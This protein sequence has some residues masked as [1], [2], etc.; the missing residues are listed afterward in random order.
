MARNSCSESL[1]SSGPLLLRIPYCPRIEQFMS[2]SLAAEPRRKGLFEPIYW[3]QSRSGHPTHPLLPLLFPQPLPV[4]CLVNREEILRG[5]LDSGVSN[6][7][8]SE[9]QFLRNLEPRTA[10]RH[11]DAGDFSV[12]TKL[13]GSVIAVY[14]GE[15]LLSIQRGSIESNPTS[16]SASR[17]SSFIPSRPLSMNEEPGNAE[18]RVSRTPSIRVKTGPIERKPSVARRSSLP[19]ISRR[20]AFVSQ[21]SSPETPLRAAVHGGTVDRLVD[22]LVH[23]LQGV[24]VAIADDNGEMPLRESK[25]RDLV[26][27]HNDFARIWWNVFRSFVTP[28]V[29]FEVSALLYTS[30]YYTDV[31]FQLMQKRY[32]GPRSPRQSLSVQ[33]CLGL[34]HKRSQVI[35]VM[36]EWIFQGGGAQDVLDDVQLF[37]TVSSFLRTPSNHLLQGSALD[38][39]KVHQAWDVLQQRRNSFASSFN[40]QTM[41]P[42]NRDVSNVKLPI[43]N[44][45]ARNLGKEP[46]DIDRISPEQLVENLD[47]MAAATFSN[48]SE[49]V[50][51]FVSTF[52]RFLTKRSR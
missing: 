23:G 19:S 44:P 42:T 48:V 2:L 46:P 50:S 25:T 12:G 32:I 29:F 7:N 49:E 33:D 31:P 14:D 41:R 11:S 15:L 3:S 43:G 47:A 35:D 26:V 36:G 27:N 1:R 45:K 21:D 10:D 5:R 39:P 8:L 22:L 13:L 40:S 9:L 37:N 52:L 38:D 17:P 16:P 4:V 18:Q 24:S 20:P 51:A 34:I 28:L 6:V 30:I